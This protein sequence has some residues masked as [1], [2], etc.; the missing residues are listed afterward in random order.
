MATSPKRRNRAW[1]PELFARLGRF[2]VRR[3]WAIVAVWAIV[4]LGAI[5]LAPQVVGELRAGGFILDDLESARAKALLQDELNVPPSAVVVV[6]HSDV[7]LAGTPAFEAAAADAIRQVPNAPYVVRIVPHTLAAR[8]VSL[9]RHTAY[10]IVFLSISPDDS[11]AALPGIRAALG[12]P[13]G[14]QVQ[15]AGGPAFYGDVQSVSESD[16][17]RSEIVSLPLAAIALLLVFGSVV[18]AAVPLIVGGSA[19]VVA[20][21]V[22]FLVASLTPM[23]IFVLNLATLLGLGLGVD[24]S[25]LMTSRFREELAARTEGST[26]D[27]VAAAVE[28]TVATAGRAVFFSG[29]TVLLGLAGLVLFEFMILR[30]VGIAGAVVVFLAVV[31]ALTLLP[32]VLAIVGGRIDALAVRKV[33]PSDDPNGPWARL[34]RR[35]MQHP[36]AVLV[37]TLAVLVVLGSPFLHVRF[38][39]PDST[40]LPA[41]VPSRAAFD[42]LANAFGEGEFAP[43][44]IAIRTDGP[45]TAPANVAALYEYS[46]RLAADPRVRRVDSLVDV[47]PRLRVDQYQ[48]LYADPNGPRDRFL[49]TVLAATTKGNLTAFTVTTPFGPNRDEGRSL[50]ADLRSPTG[51]LAPPP[52]MTVLV[53]GGAADVTDVVSRVAADFPRTAVF[54]VVSTYLV[55]FLLLRSVVLPAKALIMNTLSI[56]ASF[57]ALVWIF[58]DG[59]LSSLLGFQPL[60]FVETTQPVILFCVLFGLSMDYEVF[61][62]T[63]IKEQWDRTG[64]NQ[65][66]VA[67]GL[68]RSGRIVTS[69]AL[70]VVVVAGSFAFAD[71]VLI[72]A[73]GIGMALAVALD[74]TVVRAL[75]VPATMRLLGHWNWWLPAGLRRVP[76]VETA[77][78]A[79]PMAL[80]IAAG[81]LLAGCTTPI[82]ANAPAPHP[83]PPSAALAP[84]APVDPQPVVLPRDDSPHHRLTEWWYYTGH[85]VAEDGHRYGFEDVIF[86]AERGSFPVTWASHL[87]ITDETGQRFLYAQRTEVGPQVDIRS[88]ATVPGFSFAIG[89]RSGW[90]MDG[91]DGRDRLEAAFSADEATSAGSTGGVGLQLSLEATRPAALHLGTGWIDFGAGG[92]SYYYSRTRMTA[93]GTITVDGAQQQVVGSAWF[94]HQWGD[95]ITVGGGGWDWFAIN[96]DDETDLTLSLVRDGDGSY[97]LVYGTLVRPGGVTQNLPRDAFT[98]EVTK[99]WTSPATGADYPAGWKVTIPAEQLTIELS[100]TVAA[101]E[102]D[103]RAT[104][105]V[106]YWEGSQRVTATRAGHPEG[107][108]AYVEL[109]GYAPSGVGASAAP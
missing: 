105:G 8:Q 32:A 82:L 99:R 2:A 91:A 24:Y 57:G 37:P 90:R 96:L 29:L 34:A 47:D 85:L 84:P 14:L 46:R 42:R 53:G 95:F 26:E 4:L 17:R 44:A 16:L 106:V 100:P 25:L 10:D 68:E 31:S 50:V 89:G 76:V 79:V 23:S 104:T 102:L 59:N 56:V 18:A 60:G 109:T 38:N 101:Q 63:R 22:I 28:A 45:A 20:L 49:A 54:I 7:E 70:I 52:G 6:L 3:R 74:A 97:P 71:I 27:R 108:Q 48:L 86:R 81:A 88:S 80:L 15:L 9:D 12:Q 77:A 92:S 73:L 78:L 94:D 62:L 30:S 69:A 65:E 36:V 103:T 41:S 83:A 87:A 35:V 19:V 13:A 43:I 51:P 39:A 98:V 66:A 5:P 107:G 40:I 58:Q 64:D 1:A 55:L 33:V 67:R 72:K 75:L 93:A 61:L 11:P 21:A